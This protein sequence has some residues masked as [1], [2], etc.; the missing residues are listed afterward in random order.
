MKI[1]IVGTGYVGLVT[2]TC[3]AEIGNDVICVDNNEEKIESLKKGE[4]PIY[5][6]GLD[7]IVIKN[8]KAKRLSFTSDIVYGINESPVIFIAVSTPPKHN[9]EADLSYVARVAR[10]IAE[11]MQDYKV[12]VDKSTVPVATGQKV[13][14]TVRRYNKSGVKFDVVSNPEFLREGSAVDDFMNPDRVVV[15]VTGE[16]AAEIMTELY[17][18]LKAPIIVTDINSAEIIKHACNSFLAM[19]ISYANALAN[20]CERSGADVV[21][22]AEGMGLDKRIGKMFLNAGVGYGG[23]CFPK[24]VAAFIKISEKLGY[25]FKLLKVV[26][27]INAQQREAFIKK[28][29][30]AL[31]ILD[32][33]TVGVLGL[34]FKPNTDDIRSAPSIDVIKRLQ[35]EGAQVKV[36]DPQAMDNAK[37]V[38]SGVKFCKNPYEVAE[39]A[40]ALLLV[41]EWEEFL[42]MDL[43]RIKAVLHQ[44]V[45]ID[46]RNAFDPKA[47]E[48]QGFIYKGMGR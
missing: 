43:K 33:K 32:D 10:S 40:D 30:D 20:I 3:L 16:R 4:I 45:F 2:G 8:V 24:D 22:V 13:A 27:E 34:S 25:D 39:G 1:T 9:G 26:E 46:G 23:S 31:W 19:K 41:T 35:K 28:I 48:A 17:K 44:P 38:L 5:E 18:P 37:E 7:E 14:E 12:I 21:R 11:N 36:Y 47:M 6:P 15:G 42:K 29:E